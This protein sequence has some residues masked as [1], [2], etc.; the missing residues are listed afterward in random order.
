MRV[1]SNRGG[2]RVS[3]VPQAHQASGAAKAYAGG[4]VDDPRA[5]NITDASV[6][7]PAVGVYCVDVEGGAINV[8]GS[9][10]S[11]ANGQLTASVLLNTGPSDKEVEVETYDSAGAAADRPFYILVN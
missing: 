3:Q 7:K 11:S 1:K 9:I 10:D 6:S 5:R 2:A 4:D 8:V